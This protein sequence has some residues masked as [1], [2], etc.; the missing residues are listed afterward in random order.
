[1]MGIGD[2]FKKLVL[3]RTG[4]KSRDLVCPREKLDMTPCVARDGDCAM[5]NN[6]CCV[7]CGISIVECL[8]DENE[9]SN[10]LLNPT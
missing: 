6:Y 7:G 8:Q 5:T 2:E 4:I 3:K 1:M 10:D 9:K